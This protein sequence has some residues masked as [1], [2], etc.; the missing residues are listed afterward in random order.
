MIRF[1]LFDFTA[2]PVIGSTLS[3]LTGFG[4]TLLALLLVDILQRFVPGSFPR[5]RAASANCRKYRRE[6]YGFNQIDG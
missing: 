2:V 6:Q 4:K 3:A 1:Q 5:F